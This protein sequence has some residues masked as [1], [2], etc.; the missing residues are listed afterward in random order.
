M[1]NLVQTN[2]SLRDLINWSKNGYIII[3]TRKNKCQIYSRPEYT[4]SNK[5]VQINLSHRF[6][7]LMNEGE[8]PWYL[9]ESVCELLNKKDFLNI[10]FTNVVKFNM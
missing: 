4:S 9:I 8:W 5:V 2:N 7:C 10:Y 1:D 6:A 3:L